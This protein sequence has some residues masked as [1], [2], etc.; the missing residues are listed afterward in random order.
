VHCCAPPPSFP[1]RTSSNSRAS[2]LRP[3][4]LAVPA[5]A[6]RRAWSAVPC[7]EPCTA[8]PSTPC[9]GA[10]LVDY[11]GGRFMATSSSSSA[12]RHRRAPWPPFTPRSSSCRPRAAPFFPAVREC[13]SPAALAHVPQ[14]RSC[15]PHH[16]HSPPLLPLLWLCLAAVAAYLRPSPYRAWNVA[17]RAR[18]PLHPGPRRVPR[19]SRRAA[20]PDAEPP[21][22]LLPRR[23]PH[24]P[25]AVRVAPPPRELPAAVLQPSPAR[26]P[27]GSAAARC[28]APCIQ[29][30]AREHAVVGRCSSPD[31]A[32]F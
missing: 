29:L 15:A 11:A 24:R 6:P 9:L 21:R 28:H 4:S 5:V 20:A 26:V 23:D 30:P 7:L 14:Y 13:A 16:R 22:H 31:D 8:F 2:I 25:R 10:S 32:L 27:L 17:L 18:A 12:V 19:Q 1:T 3:R